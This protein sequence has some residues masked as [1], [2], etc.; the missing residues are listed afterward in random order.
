MSNKLNRS[1]NFIVTFK[2]PNLNG[3][4]HPHDFINHCKKSE[5]LQY[6]IF[7]WVRTPSQINEDSL[8]KNLRNNSET[9]YQM[10]F[11]FKVYMSIGRIQK[12]FFNGINVEVFPRIESQEEAIRNCKNLNKS[13]VINNYFELGE[14]KRKR[15]YSVTNFENKEIPLNH[16]EQ[17]IHI[18]EEVKKGT[19]KSLKDVEKDYPYV[20]YKQATLIQDILNRNVEF[21]PLEIDPAKVIW[22]YGK[23]GSGKTTWT[24]KHLREL[25]YK[26]SDIAIISPPSL[27]Y[28]D[29]VF[30]TLEDQNCKVLVVNEVD[31]SF[32]KYNN[33]IAWIDRITF[34]P[35]KGSQIRNNFDLIIVNSIYKPEEVFSYL[36]KDSAVQILRRI[37]NSESKSRVYQ[38][39]A[40]DQQLKEARQ[41]NLD[42]VEFQN[43]YQ[44]IVKLIPEPDYSL[45]KD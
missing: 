39:T 40:N 13:L 26:G 14:P 15:S 4:F 20:S 37:F 7:Q 32:P 11:E 23:G 28:N 42:K 12:E 45:M 9:F 19:Y 34:L 31:R 18:I 16:K 24:N 44:P 35:V 38:I 25:G 43:W 27:V 22:L 30:F 6:L 21:N 2:N 17:I 33:L 36:G 8:Q 41:L 5:V 3:F 10:Y 1:Y 29:M